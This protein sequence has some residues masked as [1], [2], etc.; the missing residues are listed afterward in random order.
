M[1]D[2]KS[3]S[4]SIKAFINN[5]SCRLAHHQVN[6]KVPNNK[7]HNKVFSVFQQKGNALSNL[8]KT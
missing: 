4:Q 2:L 7:Q 5:C 3:V 8:D 6:V 1:I